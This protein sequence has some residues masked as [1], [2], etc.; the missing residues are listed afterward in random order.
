MARSDYFV[1]SPTTNAGSIP[2]VGVPFTR[3]SINPIGPSADGAPYAHQRAE[4]H[5]QGSN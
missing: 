1:N 5:G 3:E 4:R 2:G